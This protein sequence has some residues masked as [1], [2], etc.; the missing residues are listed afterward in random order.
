M[1]TPMRRALTLLTVATLG[2]LAAAT[3]GARSDATPAL[4]G[5][6]KIVAATAVSSLTWQGFTGNDSTWSGFEKATVKLTKPRNE[7]AAGGTLFLT[8]PLKGNVSTSY[9][10]VTPT[11][12]RSCP[13]SYDAAQ[14]GINVG[15]TV[16]SVGA[17]KVRVAGGPD[18]SP[19]KVSEYG[20]LSRICPSQ[21]VA[22]LWHFAD[23]STNGYG[24]G[25]KTFPAAL[26]KQNRFTI[27][28]QGQ[29]TIRETIQS[30]DPGT[31]KRTWKLVLTLERTR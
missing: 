24:W 1:I 31:A 13:Q 3:A 20:R 11:A 4:S 29:R 17:T 16:T 30:L 2:L 10:V 19:K 21:F 18:L 12:T 7:R 23:F 22:Q 26:F 9:T 25:E 14:L 27:T 6:Y 15:L 5:G 8:V 28:L